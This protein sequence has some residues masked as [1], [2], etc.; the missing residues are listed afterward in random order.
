M[1][2]I[3]HVTVF[4]CR[5]DLPGKLS[6]YSFA[7]PTVAD[8]EVEHLTAIHVLEHHVIVMLVNDHLTHTADVWVVEE[9][10]ECG[11]AEGADFL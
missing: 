4:K 11:L 9:K 2:D 10:G 8:D 7:Q 3:V 6:C 5:T 1:D